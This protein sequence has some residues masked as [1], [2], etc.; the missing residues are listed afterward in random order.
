MKAACLW[1]AAFALVGVSAP[2]EPTAGDSRSLIAGG[3]FESVFPPV[4][5][6]KAVS[7]PPFRLDTMLVSNAD[8]ARFAH[9]HAEWRRDRI[10]RLFA[11]E[12]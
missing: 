6:D 1:V 3:R 10:A 2:C 11:D 5:G 12:R 7:V 8:F 9:D 4:T